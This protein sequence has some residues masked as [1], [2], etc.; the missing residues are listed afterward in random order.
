MRCAI[1]VPYTSIRSAPIRAF[2]LP[3]SAV[4]VRECAV[5]GLPSQPKS[6]SDCQPETMSHHLNTSVIDEFS[7]RHQFL[8]M[9]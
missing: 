7:F 9:D 1:S 4:S 2:S 6:F 5:C 8:G 3:W